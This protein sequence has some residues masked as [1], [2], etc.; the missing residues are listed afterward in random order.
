MRQ[1]LQVQRE[2][3]VQLERPEELEL[4]AKQVLQVRQVQWEQQGLQGA[5]VQRGQLAKRES[6]ALQALPVT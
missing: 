6:Q 5:K 1:A 2:P 4:L 3:L